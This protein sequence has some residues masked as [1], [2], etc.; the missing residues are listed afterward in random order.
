M[1]FLQVFGS[2]IESAD[3]VTDTAVQE[4]IDSI[5]KEM[6]SCSTRPDLDADVKTLR[7]NERDPDQRVLQ[8]FIKYHSILR[9]HSRQAFPKDHPKEDVEHPTTFLQ[10]VDLKTL[11]LS[12]LSFDRKDLCKEFLAFFNYCRAE[13]KKC[14][15]YVTTPGRS[16]QKQQPTTAVAPINSAHQ[17][18]IQLQTLWVTPVNRCQRGVLKRQHP[19]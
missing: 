7:L 19:P 10:P 8:M 13:L 1:L 2:H 16:R 11:V 15:R 12:D 18:E 5:T 9:R 6:S 4:W 17:V 14:E 3:A